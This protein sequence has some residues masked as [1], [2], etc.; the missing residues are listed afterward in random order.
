MPRGVH[1]GP[2][3][4]AQAMGY[5][6]YPAILSRSLECTPRPLRSGWR[7]GVEPEQGLAT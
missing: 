7:G 6:L 2:H 5:G 4:V 1:C 3:P